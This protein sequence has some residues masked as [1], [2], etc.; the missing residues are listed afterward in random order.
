MIFYCLSDRGLI[1]RKNE[2]NYLQGLKAGDMIVFAV[3]DGMGGHRGGDIASYFAIKG[4]EEAVIRRQEYLKAGYIRKNSPRL[5]KDIFKEANQKILAAKENDGYFKEMGT[6]LT[7]AFLYDK[8]VAIAH[9]GDSRAYVIRNEKISQVTSDHSLVNELLKG[10]YLSIYEAYNHPQK[11]VLTNAMGL[12]L[13]V[14]VDV[15][16][17]RLDQDTII[18]LCS[19]GLNS[20]LY[21]ED[22]LSIVKQSANIEIAVKKLIKKCREAGG[23]DNITVCLISEGE[24]SDIFRGGIK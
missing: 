23:F 1:R 6:T 11:N 14:P 20:H 15:Y 17:T 21:D 12:E 13:D 18:L 7:A 2:D 19:D 22:I 5:F 4:L 8:Q 9:V 16:Y 10:G 24:I 3:A